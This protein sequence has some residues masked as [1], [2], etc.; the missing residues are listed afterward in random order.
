MNPAQ[1]DSVLAARLQLLDRG[2]AEAARR[3]DWALTA[4]AARWQ[5]RSV[6]LSAH[7]LSEAIALIAPDFHGDAAQRETE[8]TIA[9]APEN[10]TR[11]DD[12]GFAPA[13]YVCWLAE[14]PEEG[15]YPIHATHHLEVKFVEMTKQHG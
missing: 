6:T 9:W 8:V 10:C 5:D 1:L 13:G 14:Y 12:G 4:R 7:Q 3:L 11:N 2:D 15:C